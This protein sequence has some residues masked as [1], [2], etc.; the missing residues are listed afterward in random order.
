MIDHAHHMM[1]RFLRPDDVA[2]DATCGN[3]QDTLFLASLLPQGKLFAFDIQEVAIKRTEQKLKEAG[4]N[5]NVELLL[6]SHYPFPQSILP[7]TIRLFI[8]NLGYL[9]GGNKSITTLTHTSL[10]SVEQALQLLQKGG[11]ISLMLY[12]GHEEGAKEAAALLSFAQNLPG[13]CYT[14][15]HTKITNRKLAPEHLWIQ[16]TSPQPYNSGSNAQRH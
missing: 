10:Q 12:P 9:P 1:Q 4:L 6:A 8:Y 11:A 7:G 3:G 13:Q 5:Q 15:F 2:V 14:V 16:E